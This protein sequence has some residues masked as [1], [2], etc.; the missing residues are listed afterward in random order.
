MEQYL[1]KDKKMKNDIIFTI[2]GAVK[3]TQKAVLFKIQNPH[4]NDFSDFFE[5]WIPKSVIVPP[6]NQSNEEREFIR[7]LQAD[8]DEDTVDLNPLVVAEWFSKK[9]FE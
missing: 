4:G 6:E 1:R 2:G 8:T 9:L 3:Q 7:K 5:K